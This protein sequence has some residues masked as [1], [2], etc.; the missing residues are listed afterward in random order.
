MTYEVRRWHVAE[1]GEVSTDTLTTNDLDE[2]RRLYHAAARYRWVPAGAVDRGVDP[3]GFTVP[4]AGSPVGPSEAV[5]RLRE[6]G[7]ASAAAA[8]ERVLQ[9]GREARTTAT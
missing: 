3:V 4:S 1:S 7:D 5:Q 2:A 9:R 8:L 6:H